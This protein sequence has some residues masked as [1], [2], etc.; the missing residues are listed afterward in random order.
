MTMRKI[1]LLTV[2]ICLCSVPAWATIVSINF[3]T[4]FT[5]TPDGKNYGFTLDASNSGNYIPPFLTITAATHLLTTD[6]PLNPSIYSDVNKIGTVFWGNMGNLDAP[7]GPYYGLG[8]QNHTAGGSK[9]ISGNGG[10]SDEALIF[11][12]SY[13]Q[14][15]DYIK[16]TLVGLNYDASHPTDDK[17]DIIVL[18]LGLAT[19]LTFTLSNLGSDIVTLDFSTLPGASGSLTQFAVECPQGHFGVGGLEVPVPPA[20]LLLGSGLLGLGLLGWRRRQQKA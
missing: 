8:V 9:G 7:H 4:G 5:P 2:C 3:G 12:F 11:T 20:V 1:V 13:P 15:V 19:E 16:L 10:D 6:D 17:N 14:N 18:K